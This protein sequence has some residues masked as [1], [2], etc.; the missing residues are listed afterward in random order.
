[1]WLNSRARSPGAVTEVA[2]GQG[3]EQHRDDDQVESA[4]QD[5]HGSS[6]ETQVLRR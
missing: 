6:G 2:S 3:A 5:D 4:H 1:M